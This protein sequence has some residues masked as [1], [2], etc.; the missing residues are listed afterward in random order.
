MDACLHGGS[1][2][3]PAMLQVHISCGCTIYIICVF[4]GMYTFLCKLTE[5]LV[6]EDHEY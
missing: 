2:L 3:E 4:N 5:N 1:K 6:Q